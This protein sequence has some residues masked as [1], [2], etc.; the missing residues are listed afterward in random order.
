MLELAAATASDPTRRF[1]SLHR[2]GRLCLL[3]SQPGAAATHLLAAEKSA[4]VVGDIAHALDA[5]IRAIGAL[6]EIGERT[7]PSLQ[8]ELG[9]LA[10]TCLGH[11]YLA[12][13]LDAKDLS[14]RVAD[15]GFDAPAARAALVDVDR[16]DVDG[17]AP[18]VRCLRE[19]IRTRHICYGSPDEAVLAARRALRIARDHDLAPEFGR[20]VKRFLVVL[21][22]RGMLDGDEGRRLVEE[23]K[24]GFQGS[25]NQ[26]GLFDVLIN[27]GVWLVDTGRYPEAEEYLAEAGRVGQ[28]LEVSPVRGGFMC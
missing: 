15:Y 5:R 9:E 4:R 17:E 18:P 14:I 24:I 22:Y 27:L 21:G 19:T 8:E 11:G 25:G 20:A 16:L 7:G 2:L 6:L 1:E 10:S 23:A 12:T 28:Y 26:S 13:Y 3:Q